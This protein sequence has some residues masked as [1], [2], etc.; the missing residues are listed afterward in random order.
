[1]TTKRLAQHRLAMSIDTVNLEDIF[2]QVQ[3]NANDL[4]DISPSMQLTTDGN[5]RREGGVHTIGA[6]WSRVALKL[7]ERLERGHVY[8][9]LMRKGC[10][11]WP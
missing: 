1:V 9:L 3:A 5:P 4:H 6:P 11:R 8:G 7:C 10:L 2:R